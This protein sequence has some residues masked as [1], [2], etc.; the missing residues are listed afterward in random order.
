MTLKENFQFM[1]FM[2]L[3]KIL[4]LFKSIYLARELTIQTEFSNMKLKQRVKDL[5]S[6]SETK[7]R[8]HLA[9]T[10]IAF[11]RGNIKLL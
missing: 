6:L 8:K 5:F 11:A 7:E 1:R 4:Y 3:S 10:R 9:Y 2:Y